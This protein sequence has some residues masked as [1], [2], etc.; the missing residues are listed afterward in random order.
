MPHSQKDEL[1]R[2]VDIERLRSRRRTLKGLLVGSGVFGSAGII[3]AQQNSTG[4]IVPTINL[5]LDDS[6]MCDTPENSNDDDPTTPETP[7]SAEF[8]L[9]ESN[10]TGTASRQFVVNTEDSECGHIVT[11]TYSVCLEVQSSTMSEAV[12]DLDVIAI[13]EG[14]SAVDV[15][16]D[17]PAVEYYVRTD[18][19]VGNN[20]T[21]DRTIKIN[22]TNNYS[23][24]TGGQITKNSCGFVPERL[25]YSLRIENNRPIMTID[26][27]T[28]DTAARPATFIDDA[29]VPAVQYTIPAMQ[30]NFVPGDCAHPTRSNS[31]CVFKD[32]Q[33]PADP[34]DPD[35]VGIIILTTPDP[36]AT[37]GPIG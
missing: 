21:F 3:Q 6:P 30:I 4:S 23:A 8:E 15:N 18:G 24:V 14:L 36:S 33:G 25:N 26:A 29:T 10:Y 13:V 7:S 32:S 20:R 19:S 9:N 34:D 2:I 12:V 28:R 16:S 22:E 11:I 31:A 37:G 27:L 1:L 17:E 5:L 35:D